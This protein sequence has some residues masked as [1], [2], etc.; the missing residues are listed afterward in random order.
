[1]TLA[2]SYK[3]ILPIHELTAVISEPLDKLRPRISWQGD[4]EEITIYDS[5]T[6]DIWNSGHLLQKKQRILTLTNGV[7]EVTQKLDSHPAFVID[8]PMGPVR[9]KLNMVS[10]LRRLMTIGNARERTYHIIF[11]D[12]EEKT[13]IRLMLKVFQSSKTHGFCLAAIQGLRG[14]DKPL[15]MLTKKLLSKG[16]Y[17]PG[18][19]FGYQHLFPTWQQYY[20]KPFVELSSYDRIFEAANG[21][22]KAYLPVIRRNEQGI[23]DDIDTE[24]LHDYRIG[25]RKIRSVLSLLK[26]VYETEQSD[27]L[28]ANF[29]TLMEPT[30]DLRDLDVYLLTQNDYYNLLPQ[31]LHLGLNGM[32]KRFAQRRNSFYEELKNH[33]Q[34]ASYHNLFKKIEDLFHHEEKLKPGPCADENI[35]AFGRKL[36]WKRYKKIC[37]LA[38]TIT[39]DTP[40]EQ[41]HELRIQCKK[42]RYLMEIFSPLFD[43]IAIKELIRPLKKLQDN[44]GLFNDYCVQ[45]ES[46]GH[47]LN[48]LKSSHQQE[49]VVIAQTV[50]ALIMVMHQKQREERAKVVNNFIN[51]NSPETE[52]RFKLLFQHKKEQR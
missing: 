18:P 27:E 16:Q 3:F 9:T 1:M 41:V 2:K 31:E 7:D 49:D 4:E 30:G 12:D 15:L 19:S 26:G 17:W 8:L 21:I 40:D 42:L 28:K 24:F 46:L 25:L 39:D 51:F 13:Q 29:R 6:Q 37:V 33:L 34:S 20:P 10:S 35:Q 14:Y 23:I 48:D 36:I 38:S 44:L 52:N 43:R 32:F 11:V 45:Q 47:F 5:F 22:I 50:G